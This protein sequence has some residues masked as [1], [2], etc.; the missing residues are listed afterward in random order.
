MLASIRSMAEPLRIGICGGT[1]NPVHIGHLLI[2]QD[3]LEQARL[4]RVLFIP[5]ATPPH[6]TAHRLAPARHRLEMLRL[7]IRGDH[8]FAVDDLEMRRGGPSY[9]VET[10]AELKRRQPQ[11]EFSFIIGGDSLPDLPHW[12]EI[13]RLVRLCRF[14]AVGRPGFKPPRTNPYRALLVRG[15]AC[16]VSSTDIRARR[17]RQQSIRYLVPDAVFR[18][19]QAHKLYR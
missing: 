17:G 9:S 3:A 16:E 12:R 15:H 13:D 2:A 7:A 10:L 1:F 8:R 4:D 14:I 6:K 18:Y 11:A 5:C 19:I